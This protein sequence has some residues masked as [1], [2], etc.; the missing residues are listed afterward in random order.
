MKSYLLYNI[1]AEGIRGINSKLRVP[2]SKG[3]SIVFGPNGSGKTSFLQAIEW[4]LTGGLPYLSGPDFRKEDAI[5]NMFNEGKKATVSLVLE[6][7]K[8]AIEVVR[9]RKM[10][11]TTTTSSSLL[12]RVG[13]TKY[14]D[15]KAQEF[16]NRELG[17]DSR[18][19]SRAVYLHQEDIQE[20]VSEEPKARSE[21]ID[22][23]LGTEEIR[24]LVDSLDVHLAIPKAVKQLE[25][26][27]SRNENDKIQFA[28]G[29]RRRLNEMKEELLK[30]GFA[31]SALSVE[32]VVTQIGN[33]SKDLD[34]IAKSMNSTAPNVAQPEPS[35]QSITSRLATIKSAI[36]SLDR[37]RVA[38]LQQIQR[39]KISLKSA[40]DNFN[41]TDSKIVEY[42]G[43]SSLT[44]LLAQKKVLEKGVEETK[45]ISSDIN[46][47][48]T[49]LVSAKTRLDALA[50]EI[51][52]IRARTEAIEKERGDEESQKRLLSELEAKI[53]SAK[54]DIAK[55]DSLSQIV[56]LSA[57]YISEHSPSKC[58]TCNQSIDPKELSN[59]LKERSKNLVSKELEKLRSLE[60]ELSRE[61]REKDT[62]LMDYKAARSKIESLKAST[63]EILA[64][65]PSEFAAGDISSKISEL[66]DRLKATNSDAL[67]KSQE[68]ESLNLKMR[69]LNSLVTKR[70]QLRKQLDSLLGAETQGV[71]LAKSVGEKMQRQSEREAGYLKTT[72]LDTLSGH[73]AKLEEVVQYLMS[74]E[75]LAKIENDIP[76][77]TARIS[78]L[79]ARVI[80]L[81][82]LGGSLAAIREACAQYQKESVSQELASIEKVLN[83]YYEALAGHLLFPELKI[84]IEK[85]QPLL[86]SV[87]ATGKAAS[88]YIP[89]RFS[90]AQADTVA[91]S[92]FFSNHEKLCTGLGLTILD[93]PEQNMDIA[94]K[95]SL[96][97]LLAKLSKDHQVLLSTQ[98]ESFMEMLINDCSGAKLLK[99]GDWSEDGC[100]ISS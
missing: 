16:L 87:K 46:S 10:G 43:D 30:K 80:S 4:C 94:H 6:D 38:A 15:D 50:Q 41:E 25:G 42:G 29:M 93:E 37:S 84:S 17:L 62:A 32:N 33:L 51:E 49:K 24:E 27:I 36:T 99:L 79:K 81:Q 35:V 58:P 90:M 44:A 95:R 13:K 91:I 14:E 65:V 56:T 73:V 19:F 75:E 54:N 69:D 82:Q 88:T 9:T 18:D 8:Q 39:Q 59:A 70:G 2:L 66:T 83:S 23:L 76:N 12:V 72:E 40:L 31:T 96:S 21:A 86:Y 100:I 55:Y 11:K 77:I 98:D 67:T 97:A 48:L 47:T 28:I 45:K 63:Y 68:M 22:K 53:E 7:E 74:Y 85:D 5:V 1:E 92:L 34:E 89:T 64:N 20:L 57:E 52:K 71:D 61:K 3:M 26:E 78:D 60:K